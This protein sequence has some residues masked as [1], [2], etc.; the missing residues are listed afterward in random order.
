MK[1]LS[2]KPCL[3]RIFRLVS[4]QFCDSNTADAN[5]AGMN[6]RGD[7]RASHVSPVRSAQRSRGAGHK[8][9]PIARHARLV[10]RSVGLRSRLAP[11]FRGACGAPSAQHLAGQPGAPGHGARRADSPVA[12][13]LSFTCRPHGPGLGRLSPAV[14]QNPAAR[15]T[16]CPARRLGQARCR[17]TAPGGG[18]FPAARRPSRAASR[19]FCLAGK[20]G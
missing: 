11:H 16:A 10:A 14:Q 7:V 6:T 20:P 5:A 18:P 15:R 1:F 17:V 3:A 4:R 19:L 8:P 12:P 9:D 13:A 2:K